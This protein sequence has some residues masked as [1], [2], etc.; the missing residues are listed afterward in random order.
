MVLRLEQ[1]SKPRATGNI[2]HWW[3]LPIRPEYKDFFDD[4]ELNLFY[5][6][7]RKHSFLKIDCLEITLMA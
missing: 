6:K 2:L 1:T 5:A 7:K 4:D 3:L